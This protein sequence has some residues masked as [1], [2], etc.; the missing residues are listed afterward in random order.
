MH[1]PKSG[2]TEV[3]YRLAW[4]R[5]YLKKYG[6]LEN[7]TRGVWA[8]T[9]SGQQLDRVDPRAVKRYVREQDRG[10]A[11]EETPQVALMKGLKSPGKMNYCQPC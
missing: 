7:S 5:T 11:P 6:V 1:N 8:L 10:I 2:Q 4:T 9:K 3:S